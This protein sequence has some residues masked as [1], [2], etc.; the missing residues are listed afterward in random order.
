MSTR[1]L[2]ITAAVISA[3]LLAGRFL[4]LIRKALLARAFG[5]SAAMDALV[6]ALSL[7]GSLGSLLAGPL[8]MAVVP[9]LTQHVSSNRHDDFEAALSSLATWGASVGVA[10]AA[11]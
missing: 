9:V 6:V 5:V 4:G 7:P 10:V 1:R 11:F 3:G 8:V 2:T